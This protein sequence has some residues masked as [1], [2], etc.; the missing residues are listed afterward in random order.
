MAS[1]GRSSEVRVLLDGVEYHPPV[2]WTDIEVLATFDRGETQSNI[3]TDEFEFILDAYTRLS[4]Y[5]DSGLSGGNGI[6]EPFP[7]QIEA[8][9]TLGTRSVFEGAIT[10]KDAVRNDTIGRI[11]API[12]KTA[13]LRTLDERLSGLTYLGLFEEGIITPADFFDV[14]YVVD[15]P[16]KATESLIVSIT[17]FSLARELADLVRQI[18]QQIANIAGDAV[19][20]ATGV[21]GAAIYSAAVLVL[22]I[23][24]AAALILL[25]TDLAQDLVSAFAMPLRTHKGM[26]LITLLERACEKLGYRFNSTIPELSQVVFLPSNP[27]LDIQ[28]D[29]KGFLK[30]PGT[31]ERGY[32]GPSDF[33]YLCSEMF[34]LCRDLFNARYQL[35]GDTVQFHSENSPY[36]IRNAS[37]QL[38]DTLETAY[39]Y[40]TE[41]L[42]SSVFIRFS[43]DQSDLYTLDEYQGTSFQVI[44]EPQTVGASGRTNIT[45]LD[46]VV[47]PVAL[48]SRKN[49]LN[50]FENFLFVLAQIVDD[51]AA[52]FG[53]NIDISGRIAAKVGVL[54][55]S[56]NNHAV[57]KLLYYEGDR[58]PVNHRERFSARGLWDEYHSYKSFIS[59]NFRRQR[60]V[61][62][63]VRIPFGFADFVALI[64]NSYFRDASGKVGKVER[65]SWNMSKDV[66]TV[67]YWTEE[68]YTKNLKE[69][70]IEP[71]RDGAIVTTS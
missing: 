38:P 12:D 28:D 27:V 47:F 26:K 4:Q 17:I 58:L 70:Y 54:R 64:D 32:P 8:I 71:T 37:Y 40:N 69:T 1:L 24:Y 59:D 19:G 42:N 2:G 23:A 62:E 14:Q 3:T 57:P 33:G 16:D 51:A 65:L 66:A 63:N 43:T 30:R 45:G 60:R 50:G 67:T 48:G 13:G 56:Q 68:V 55:V 31:I 22:N 20:G 61:F 5:I 53:G 21:A 18:G 11:T 7:L 15:N 41:D 46:E 39:R 25:I 49:E 6:F 34:Q 9:S 10:L 36:W 44:T 29:V 35:V 52:I